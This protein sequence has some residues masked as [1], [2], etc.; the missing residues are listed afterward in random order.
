MRWVRRHPL[1]TTV[2]TIA[3]LIGA[4]GQVGASSAQSGLAPLDSFTAGSAEPLAAPPSPSSAS[5]SPSPSASPTSATPVATP[6]AAAP[7]PS[8]SAGHGGTLATS[9]LATLAV[10]GRAPKTGYDREGK[11]GPAWE[12]VDG[13]A[14][15]TRNDVLKRDLV[16]V[17]YRDGDCTVATGVLHDPYTGRTINFRRGPGTS[18]KVQI[19]HVV[20]LSDAWQKGAQQWSQITRVDFANDPDNL[21]AV[22][23]PTNDRKGDGDAAT[24]LPPNKSFRCEYV[25]RQIGVKAAYHLWVTRAEKEAMQRVLSACPGQTVV[26]GRVR[27]VVTGQTARATATSTPK[28]VAKAVKPAVKPAPTS[29]DV[30]YANCTAARAAGAAPLHKGQAGYRAALDRDKDGV[31]CE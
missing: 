9:V 17:T 12:D 2:I 4:I 7:A 21:L 27:T 16:Q 25:A 31:A 15:D 20:A 14:C 5:L 1:W 11:F 28:P 13:N 26:T 29:A 10:K 30:Y 18:S 19:D 3:L 8:S 22:D 24:W 23:G 6:S